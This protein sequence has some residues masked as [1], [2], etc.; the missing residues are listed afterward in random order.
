MA[1]QEYILVVN[2]YDGH[3][4][5][6]ICPKV[7]TRMR[8]CSGAQSINSAAVWSSVRAEVA[9]KFGFELCPTIWEIGVNV[10]MWFVRNVLLLAKVNSFAVISAIARVITQRFHIQLRTRFHHDICVVT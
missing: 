2:A 5:A 7:T 3:F 9:R 4:A 10:P 8:S 6:R 1:H